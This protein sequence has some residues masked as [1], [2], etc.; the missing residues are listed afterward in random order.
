MAITIPNTFVAGTKIEATPMNANFAETANAV[1]KR[2]D[3]LTGNLGANA[4][5]TVDGVDVS[6]IPNTSGTFNPLFAQVVIGT[7]DTNGIRLDLES[8]T[9]AVRE[10]DD[11]AYGPLTSGLLTT[12]GNHVPATNDG[13]SLGISGTAWADLFLASGAVINF[14]AGDVTVTHSTN[15]LTFAGA[16]SGYIFNDGNVGIGTASPNKIGFARALTIE[17]SGQ[18]GIE[19]VGSQTTDAA[20]GNLNWINAAASNA[21]MGQ[22]S[23]RR[24][25]ADNSGALTFST[26]NGGSGA[27]RMRITAAGNVGIGVT[28]KTFTSGKAVEIG[29]AGN[30]AWGNGGG[31]MFVASNLYYNADFKYAAT[32]AIAAV[33]LQDGII[34]FLTAPSGTADTTA[35]LTERF[36]VLNGGNIAIG[37]TARLYLDGVAGTGDTYITEVAANN[38][39]VVSGGANVVSFGVAST[40]ATEF[41]GDVRLQATKK[42]YLD[43]GGDTYLEEY[44]AN[45]VRLTVG[46]SAHSAWNT[47]GQF[48]YY[49][50]PTTAAAANAYI[51]QTDYIR[52]STSSIRYK[53]DIATL[54]GSDA[55][56]A[57]MAMRPITYRGKTDEDQRRF[58]GFIAEEMQEIAPLLCTYD[59]GGES[60]TPNYV[61]Y[62]R[63]T[64]YLVAVVQQQQN[65]INALKARIH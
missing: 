5:I 52:R 37:A 45:E 26:W 2:G 22:I 63:V 65:E 9:L 56:A 30:I 24:D 14:N 32:N 38:I 19:I 51:A 17:S 48:I 4:G 44:G 46:G 36:R 20:I 54:D 58:V 23:T 25:G 10:G 35:T 27:E 39:R 59:D 18:T 11:S 40:D 47:T 29:A 15:T 43:S 13:G 1:D 55:L 31:D 28:P 12:S 6:T 62:D 41:F 3:T 57:V 60:G 53:H 7:A 8:G 33:R 61:T 34:K 16:A 49:N 50:P 21:N 42:L 64:A